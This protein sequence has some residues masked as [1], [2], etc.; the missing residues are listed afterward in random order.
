MVKFSRN[1]ERFETDIGDD[2]VKVILRP[3][4]GKHYPQRFVNKFMDELNE[5][6]SNGRVV[7]LP[8][9]VGVCL[10][11]DNGSTERF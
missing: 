9:D 2:V 3:P 11:Y 4:K 5:K 1:G 7:V 10:I 6:V 8:H